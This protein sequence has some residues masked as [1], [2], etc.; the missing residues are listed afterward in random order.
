MKLLTLLLITFFIITA[1]NRPNKE[2]V[3]VT[4]SSLP[5]IAN[6]KV[7]E[8]WA[9]YYR[10]FDPQFSWKK[11]EKEE[12]D[13]LQILA[14]S[15]SPVWHSDFKDYYRP[16]LIFSPD[17]TRYIDIDSYL[18]FIV[19]ENA[20]DPEI[21]YSPDQEVNL[22]NLKDSSVNRIAFR[23]PNQ[24]VEDAFWIGA[25]TISLVENNQEGKPMVTIIDLQK[26]TFTYYQYP[27]SVTTT[28]G[29]WQ[30]RIKKAID[31]LPKY[32]SVL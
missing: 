1:C 3:H 5:E 29:Y 13:S 18:W 14:G 22:I 23:G 24:R 32:L 8:D 15:V 16:L 25:Q 12:T 27:D 21:G 20:P 4:Q 7:F 30:K 11:F 31:K 19:N 10:Q 17:S 2:K 28:N 9:N 26:N 6:E